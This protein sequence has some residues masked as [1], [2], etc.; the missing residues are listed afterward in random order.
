MQ[1]GKSLNMWV[2]G[3]LTFLGKG[4][5]TLNVKS[6]SVIPK[7]PKM[8]HQ[9]SSFLTFLKLL[10]K[11]TASIALNTPQKTKDPFNEVQFVFL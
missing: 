1:L 4:S 11:E 10:W 8:L 3:S 7:F 5:G 9:F 6:A 2:A